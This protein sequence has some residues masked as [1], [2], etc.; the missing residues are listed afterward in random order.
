MP[1][2]WEQ[3]TE[4]P[5]DYTADVESGDPKV[6]RLRPLPVEGEVLSTRRPQRLVALAHSAADIHHSRAF[7]QGLV[8]AGH[9][10]LLAWL[11]KNL[12]DPSI[13]AR[14]H[15][16]AQPDETSAG[17]AAAGEVV[18]GE[19]DQPPLL[20]AAM[21][22]ADLLAAVQD[23]QG[24]VAIGDRA[25]AIAEEL[26]G[27]RCP[28]VPHTELS[29]WS[30]LP[31]VWP[32][33]HERA[34]ADQLDGNYARYLAEA[35]GILRHV[36]PEAV[37]TVSRLI[38]VALNEG[39]YPAADQ[40]L[41]H[42][43]GQATG[44][45]QEVRHRG[46][47]ALARTS[48]T[49][50][51]DPDLRDAAAALL[52]VA[53]QAL[54]AGSLTLAAELATLA[55]KLLFHPE[56]HSDNL[57]SP[58]LETPDD[59]L[60]SWRASQV[61][62]LLA[63]SS[64]RPTR[65][66]VSTSTGDQ[67]FEA[68]APARSDDRAQ[69]SAQVGAH[70]NAPD[71]ADRPR[72]VVVPGSYPR[73]ATQV[74]DELREHAQVEVI[75]LASRGHLRGL[76]VRREL[77]EERLRQV[78]GEQTGAHPDLAARLAGAQ[79]L[80]IDWADRG[81]LVAVLSLP[82]DRRPAVTLRIHS[83]D[84]LSCWIH[85]MDW[86]CIDDLVVVSDHLR[87]V[88]V[89][90]LGDRLRH[91][92]IHVIPNVVNMSRIPTGPKDEGALRTVLMIGWAQ[93]VK[94]PIWALEVLSRLRQQDPCWRLVLVGPDFGRTRVTSSQRYAREFRARLVDPD[95]CGA[96]HFTGETEDVA[97]WLTASG[98]VLSSSR[99][100]SFGVGLVEGAASGALPVVRD[101]P[102]F[103]A[104]DGARRLFPADWVVQDPEDAVERILAHADPEVWSAA[105]QQARSEAV[106][107][108]LSPGPAH[109]IAQVVL[110]QPSP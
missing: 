102:L 44:P 19:S 35:V 48:L 65:G 37:D 91:T 33:L 43:D 53:D 69:D 10:V 89:R 87:D 66:P 61:A 99:R 13:V 16:L 56:L 57:T 38:G 80:F 101:W 71:D 73:F 63:S 40:L 103:A 30:T 50:Q 106:V 24:L 108:F 15:R 20:R 28:V 94:D 82:Q 81:A 23:C 14:Q 60:A 51:E 3:A 64:P 21:Q 52:P 90:L 22:D 12:L 34:A 67:S 78:C 29:G 6:L 107:R 96:V 5:P 110:G 4:S 92:R 25:R 97:P 77:V 109:V 54:T 46:Q 1:M 39:E 85:V 70:D 104:L 17:E 47:R 93:R 68:S 72:V 11:D 74:T 7:L 58:L 75:D 55:L 79:A 31:R 86:G 100:E 88:V 32:Q 45:V 41:D 42:L 62:E 59:Y 76:G 84:A 8:M 18:A 26:A 36:P 105:A 2:M 27:D 9:D 95:V 49:G 83:M 98:F